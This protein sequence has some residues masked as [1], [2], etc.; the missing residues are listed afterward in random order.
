MAHPADTCFGLAADPMNPKA[1]QKLQAIK[2]R[3]ALK[4]M[5]LMLPLSLKS[6]I[7]DYAELDDFAKGVCQN[8]LPGPVTLVLPKGP[9]I[10]AFYFPET[11][12]IGLRIPDHDLTQ[13]LL[14]EFNGPLVTTS[15]N[16]SGLPP[17]ADHTGFLA[18]FQNAPTLPDAIIEGRIPGKCEP[19]AVVE[20]KNGKLNVL[21]AGEYGNK[22]V[23]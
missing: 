6:Q 11:T 2:G 9:Q 14:S 19:S 3:G 16:L 20:V 10:P 15:A 13:A 18:Q 23:K 4:P 12:T 1:I 8:L 22:I 5:S 7:A 17:V 21:R